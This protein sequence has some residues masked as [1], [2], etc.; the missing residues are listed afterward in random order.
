MGDSGCA[1]GQRSGCAATESILI[2]CC[3]SVAYDTQNSDM[4]PVN[5]VANTGMVQKRCLC[6]QVANMDAAS[7]VPG[8]KV[9]REVSIQCNLLPPPAPPPLI[10]TYHITASDPGG[11]KSSQALSQNDSHFLSRN[12]VEQHSGTTESSKK[13]SSSSSGTTDSAEKVGSCSGATDGVTK[14]SNYSGATDNPERL[15]NYNGAANSVEKVSKGRGGSDGAKK[16]NIVIEPTT[17]VEWL[18]CELCSFTTKS[19]YTLRDHMLAHKGDKCIQCPICLAKFAKK[20]NVVRHM[21]QTHPDGKLYKSELY[22]C[23][24]CPYKT[25]NKDALE[26]HMEIHM[27]GKEHT[28]DVCSYVASRPSLMVRHM[29]SHTGDKPY[30]CEMCTFVTAWQGTLERHVL[31]K[32]C[33]L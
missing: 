31:K 15:G 27:K 16:V 9:R 4:L 13:V 1:G 2:P 24:L 3:A 12:A 14:E 7:Q 29:R 26:K 5:K 33:Q 10:R 18:H 32:H 21:Q 22:R 8:W 6:G 19:K 30:K 20:H 17:K 28:C 25:V 23:D 11:A